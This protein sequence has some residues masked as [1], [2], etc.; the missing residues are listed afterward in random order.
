MMRKSKIPL[1]I[2][3]SCALL[4]FAACGSDPIVDPIPEPEAP[5]V[6]EP[7]E[8]EVTPPSPSEEPNTPSVKSTG[9]IFL[10]GEIHGVEEMMDIQLEI[11]HD[12]YHNEGMRHLFVE[13]GYFTAE[14]LNIWM[15][16]D[17]D[18]ILDELYR[19]WRGTQVHVPY[20]KVFFKTI[21]DEYPGTIFHG[22]D[23]GHQ[24]GTTGR[25]FIKYLEDNGLE[26]SEQY[27]LAQEAI[28]Q[29]R[30]TYRNRSFDDEYREI[31]M[32][33][34]FIREFDK[35]TDQNIM[36]IYGSAHA[37]F[38]IMYFADF[39]TMAENLRERYGDA[40][41]S[42]YLH[43]LLKAIDPIRVDMITVG[44]KEYEAS[45]FGKQDLSVWFDSL[46]HREF[47]RLEDA[48]ED[49][50]NS[51]KTGDVLPYD[52]YPMFI[53][54]GQVFVIEYT[55][56]DGSAY[57]EYLRSDGNEWQGIPTTEGFT[58]D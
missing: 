10:Y 45:Y 34:N 15:K 3:I 31:K 20:T 1:F 36:G 28:E 44:G 55:M 5:S 43:F 40:V 27:L 24:Y 58:V 26:G 17:S 18:D 41:H 39:P 11:W 12:Y 49:F 13:F 46:L 14:F 16:S 2:V 29:G 8:P 19:D 30:H 53:E 38:G 7:Q 47:W 9:Q 54:T 21:K 6:S 37:Y 50:K 23:I 48:Y 4:L 35:L 32:T 52:N 25:R 57:R 22:T 42:V 51:P 33:E 56:T